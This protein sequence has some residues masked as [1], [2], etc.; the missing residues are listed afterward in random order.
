M[1]IDNSG[2]FF[3]SLNF[4]GCAFDE[5]FVGFTSRR[6]RCSRRSS[7]LELLIDSIDEQGVHS[8]MII[9]QTG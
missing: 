1:S 3:C 8:R 2:W 9:A 4:V 7:W 6:R 5:P